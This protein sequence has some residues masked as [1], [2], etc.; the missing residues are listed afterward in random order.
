MTPV[1]TRFRARLAP[2][3]HGRKLGLRLQMA[4]ER[5]WA[6]PPADDEWPYGIPIPPPPPSPEEH[7]GAL[8]D[9]IELGFFAPSGGVGLGA[10]QA[11]RFEQNGVLSCEVVSPLPP[12][13]LGGVACMLRS[14]LAIGA[15]WELA[16]LDAEELD[17]QTAS[18]VTFVD[19]LPG[20]A[21]PKAPFELSVD[22]LLDRRLVVEI[23][24]VDDLDEV[25]ARRLAAISST[26]GMLIER[27]AFRGAMGV[28]WCVGGLES[29]NESLS[30]QWIITIAGYFGDREAIAP[31]VDALAALHEQH[32]VQSVLIR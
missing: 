23:E 16:S 25:A 8:V 27:G 13:P 11:R 6:K 32:P 17:A 1:D 21:I 12:I 2:G 4:P 18:E 5:D 14:L 26:W 7:V 3:T 19:G 9:A 20:L 22:R 31:L 29:A 24:M 15:A 30:N 28:P 10:V